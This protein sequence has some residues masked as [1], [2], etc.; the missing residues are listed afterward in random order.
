MKMVTKQNITTQKMDHTAV[1]MTCG[2]YFFNLKYIQKYPIMFPNK[3]FDE[4]PVRAKMQNKDG[5]KMMATLSFNINRIWS[6]VHD[7]IP[8]RG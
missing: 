5:Q 1:T 3:S 2:D 4:K 7:Q 8:V 6:V